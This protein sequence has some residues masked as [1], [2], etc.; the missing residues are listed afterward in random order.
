LLT[1]DT[2]MHELEIDYSKF[3]KLNR[4]KQASLKFL[5][6]LINKNKKMRNKH[7]CFKQ[8]LANFLQEQNVQVTS[9]DKDKILIANADLSYL[10]PKFALIDI[11][12]STVFSNAFIINTFKLFKKLKT[13]TI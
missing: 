9:I 2:K 3:F 13:L 10:I 8:T 5:V 12:K 6:K 7:S 11:K 1:G 4:K